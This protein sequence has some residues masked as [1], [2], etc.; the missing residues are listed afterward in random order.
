[1]MP[2]GSCW[3]SQQGTAEATAPGQLSSWLNYLGSVSCT[4]AQ[5]VSGSQ[6]LINASGGVG[7]LPLITTDGVDD[8]LFGNI[9]KGSAWADYEIGVVGRRLSF[10]AAGRLWWAYQGGNFSLNDQTAALVRFT[11][12]GGANTSHTGFDPDDAADRHYS[13]DALSGVMNARVGG[14]IVATNAGTVTSRADGGV[15]SLGATAAGATPSNISLQAMYAFPALTADQ[16]TYLRAA[17]TFYTG[18]NC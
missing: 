5:A 8:V 9:T 6:P 7:G 11:V 13:G 15:L 16:R 2:P 1:M 12:A 3:I 18:I 14:S 4:L 10:T 17:L